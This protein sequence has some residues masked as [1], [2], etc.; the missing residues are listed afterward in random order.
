MRKLGGGLIAAGLILSA[1]ALAG[2]AGAQAVAGDPVKGQAVFDDQCSMCHTIKDDG[3]GPH[4]GGVVGRKAGSVAGAD[5]TD[6][7]KASGI[8]WT[9]DKLDQF[10]MGPDKMVPGTAMPV[11][12]S[13]PIE[14]R[15]LI[16]Y[17]AST[18]ASGH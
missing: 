1:G 14:R 17:L 18:A 6:A 13:D 3:Q 12:V 11:S 15:N 8:T 16:A 9:P 2:I 5:Y 7:M 4:L 10:L